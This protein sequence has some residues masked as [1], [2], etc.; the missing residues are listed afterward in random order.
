MGINDMTVKKILKT[1]RIDYFLYFRL[2]DFRANNEMSDAS[3]V[4][5]SS[6]F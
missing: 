6:L 4:Q 3:I 5:K 2:V 1:S